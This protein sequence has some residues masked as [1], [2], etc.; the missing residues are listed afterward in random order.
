MIYLFHLKKYRRFV[1]MKGNY[2]RQDAILCHEDDRHLFNRIAKGNPEAKILVLKVNVGDVILLP[3]E[4]IIKRWRIISEENG[5]L[6][7]G[8]CQDYHSQSTGG[9]MYPYKPKLR[10]RLIYVVEKSKQEGNS[11]SLRRIRRETATEKQTAPIV[12]N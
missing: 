2:N 4:Q 5:T 9:L 11:F 1:Y 6:Y 12:L 3:A 10:P 8:Y 7:L